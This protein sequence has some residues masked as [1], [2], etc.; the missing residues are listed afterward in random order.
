MLPT[1]K[2]F[3][4]NVY[5]KARL[6]IYFGGSHCIGGWAGLRSHSSTF[7]G[8]VSLQHIFWVGRWV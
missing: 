1:H 6:A 5:E 8:G 4:K 2:V 3:Q 7:A